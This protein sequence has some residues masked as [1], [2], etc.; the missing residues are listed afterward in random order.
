MREAARKVG[1][2]DGV[3]EMSFTYR[4]EELSAWC[5]ITS[6]PVRRVKV[7]NLVTEAPSDP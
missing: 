5:V 4:G 3:I 6:K 7:K 2:V 1:W